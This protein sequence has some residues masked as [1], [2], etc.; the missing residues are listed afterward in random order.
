MPWD[1][2]LSGPVEVQG[3]LGE[4][5]R[6]GFEAKVKLGITPAPASPPVHGLVEARYDGSRKI[7]DLGHSY[8]ALPS[9]RVDFTG[10]LG[11]T[12]RVQLRST[13]LDELLPAVELF[14]SVP[15]PIPIK[16]QNGAA[17]FNGTVTG[18]LI[19]PQIAGHV[20]LTNFVYAQEKIDSFNADTSAQKSGVAV[21]NA[22]LARGN[23]H[24]QFAASVALRDW[25][26][27]QGGPLSATGS[28]RGADVADVLALAGR[29]NIP[30]KG[31][32]AASG[33]ISV[34]VGN[35]LIE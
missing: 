21:R 25:R 16:L 23:L 4:R 29:K 34:T 33:Q 5:H 12:L 24:A 10:T 27:D 14:S 28:V 32:L 6:G 17:T 18:R 26:P 13:N 1:G 31:S 7:L 30:A 15:V 2:L 3:R 35:P 9:T 19:A 11:Q 20:A 8:F 22:A